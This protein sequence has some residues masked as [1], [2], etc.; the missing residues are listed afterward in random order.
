MPAP[1]F[2]PRIHA[3]PR[4][5]AA[6][7]R[8]PAAVLADLDSSPR[9]LSATDAARRLALHGPNALGGEEREPAWRVLARATANPLVILL[10]VLAVSELVAGDATAAGLMLAMA[11]IGVAIRFTQEWRADAAAADLRTMV[12]VHA[13]ALRDGAPV[14]VPLAEIVPGDVVRLAAGDMV[15]ADVRLLAAK[16]LFVTQAVLT[17]ESFPVEKFVTADTSGGTAPMLTAICCLGTSVASGSA[18]AVV[19]ETG[20][21]TV[22]GSVATSLEAPESPTAF[23]V[24][25]ARFTWFM[26]GLVAVMAPVVFV[27]TGL[28]KGNWWE[29]FFFALAVAV[30]LTPEMLP[31][32]VSV[33]LSRG[34][35]GMARKRVIVRRLDS[36]QNLGAMDVLCTDKTGTLT[37]DRVILVRHCD[38]LLREDPEVLTLAWLT[39]HFQTGLKNLLDR[40]I[41][42]HETLREHVPHAGWAKL[43]EI[44]YDF[45]RRMM[46][47][48]VATPDGGRRL[49]A[50]GSLES[51][52]ARATACAID[53]AIRPLDAALLATLTA[54]CS[55]LGAEGFRVL[56]VATRDVEVKPAY[57]RDDERDLVL[58][59]YVAFLDPPKDS[60][61][62]ALEALLA[63]GVAVKVLTGDAEAVSRRIC[64]EVGLDTTHVLR[65]DQ[66]DALDDAALAAAAGRATL[67]VRLDPAQ[68]ER[69]VRLLRS[70]GH[71]VGFLGDGVNDAPAL[72]AADVGISV[73]TAAD[74]ARESADCIL[75]D[76]DLRV[77]RD[78]VEEGRYVFANILKEIRMGASSNFGNVLSVLGA[79][80]LLPFVPMT[81]LQI[82]TL[83]LLYDCSQ[84]PIPGD[85]VDPELV[86]RPRPWSLTQIAR[87]V[88]LVGPVSSLFDFTT[89]V[90][91]VVA[92][93]CTDPARAPLFHTG[94]FVESLVTQA[95]VIHVIRTNRIPFLESRA[96]PALA[97]ATVAVILVGLWLPVSPLA[98]VLG[99]VPLPGGWWPVLGLTVAAYV[100][101]VHAVKTWLV[102]RGWID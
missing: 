11:A 83:N 6:A 81:P 9:G 19:V 76:K 61:R 10:A 39:S 64:H 98:P 66:V 14:E 38:V 58:R 23:D 63:D 59:G 28:T 53:G 78:G 52:T 102:R 75:L 71:V 41:L 95:L 82:L 44:P 96:S 21:R 51:V 69:I 43:D 36:I 12:R 13:T 74:V 88:L 15:P 56:A 40:A 4:L 68:K 45:A 18:E 32:I 26:V 30:G 87:F 27:V 94:W 84:V 22:L 46:S 48:V 73:D 37:M 5:A 77:L 47:V 91:L 20:R 25:V 50:K 2:P 35:I 16:D 86:A 42:E 85:T 80:V 72:K 8:E 33:C 79:S 7:A 34:A 60:A 57:G 17:G 92:F 49:V 89:F 65:G 70:R 1:R 55:D 62:A 101:V 29:A 99:F 3:S 67:A 90:V 54:E 97:A 31:M 93:G 24:G 100:V